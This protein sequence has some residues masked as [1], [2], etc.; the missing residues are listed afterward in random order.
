[1]IIKIIIILFIFFVLWRTFS[2]YLKGDITIRELVIWTVFWLLVSLAAILP[3]KTDILAQWLG[4]S[5]GADLLVYL[6]IIVLFFVVF[7]IIVKLEKIDREITRV[8]RE[9]AL[10]DKKE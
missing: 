1:M 4:V 5:R 7:R 2:R 3:Q 6:S 10:K 9:T 8:V